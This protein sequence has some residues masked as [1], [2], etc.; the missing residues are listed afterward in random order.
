[1]VVKFLRLHRNSVQLTVPVEL[2]AFRHCLVTLVIPVAPCVIVDDRGRFM[3]SAVAMS[4]FLTTRLVS[5]DWYTRICVGET[6]WD[7]VEQW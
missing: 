4:A 6:G 7:V 1:M 2:C 5:V 3:F